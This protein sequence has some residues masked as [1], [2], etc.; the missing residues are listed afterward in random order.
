MIHDYDTEAARRN[1]P[2]CLGDPTQVCDCHGEWICR[3]KPDENVPMPAGLIYHNGCN[4]PCDSLHGPCACG[5][6]HSVYEWQER[7]KGRTFDGGPPKDAVGPDPG[8]LDRE[9]R[10]IKEDAKTW[11]DWMKQTDSKADEPPKDRGQAPVPGGLIG[12]AG[13]APSGTSFRTYDPVARK[14]D[15]EP[16]AFGSLVTDDIGPTKYPAGLKGWLLWAADQ[17]P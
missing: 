14:F 6:W 1:L 4:G 13:V 3:P 2:R 16:G 17:L 7:L 10:A 8:W 12:S 9:F 15:D 11:P 5:A